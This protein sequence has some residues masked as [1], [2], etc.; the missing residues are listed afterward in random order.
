MKSF[1]CYYLISLHND[2]NGLRRMLPP[3]EIIFVKT[4]TLLFIQQLRKNHYLC[5]LVLSR[6]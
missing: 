4:F 2:I 5:F 3:H 6:H 1:K